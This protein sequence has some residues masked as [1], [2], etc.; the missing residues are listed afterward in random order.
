MS[1]K[2]IMALYTHCLVARKEAALQ[3]M[4]VEGLT[5]K[6]YGMVRMENV[7]DVLFQALLLD[8]VR[9][10]DDKICT[11]FCTCFWGLGKVRQIGI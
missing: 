1:E 3:D 5:E 6:E 8:N 9:F 10:E 2:Y 4:Q 11:E 7:G